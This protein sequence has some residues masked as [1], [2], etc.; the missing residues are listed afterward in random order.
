LYKHNASQAART[1]T[2]TAEIAR[3]EATRRDA[4]FAVAVSREGGSL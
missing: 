4:F 2:E 1:E 3:G